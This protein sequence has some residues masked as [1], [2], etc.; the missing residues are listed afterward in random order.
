MQPTTCSRHS[1]LL[2]TVCSQRGPTEVLCMRWWRGG[3]GR[4]HV[5]YLFS[6]ICGAVAT[7]QTRMDVVCRSV[8]GTVRHGVE[9]VQAGCTAVRASTLQRHQPHALNDGWLRGAH[10][11]VAGV[12]VASSRWCARLEPNRRGSGAPLTHPLAHQRVPPRYA[13]VLHAARAHP[14]TLAGL[15][16]LRPGCSCTTGRHA[17]CGVSDTAWPDAV[18]GLVL[19]ISRGLRPRPLERARS[20]LERARSHCDDDERRVW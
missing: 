9:V 16:T 17:V 2:N 12:R 11:R 20:Q 8:D 19:P 1:P 4:E 13:H 18:H 6:D 15:Q 10:E 14:G 3:A 7:E 5:R